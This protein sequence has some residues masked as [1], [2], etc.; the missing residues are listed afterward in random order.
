MSLEEAPPY[1]TDPEGELDRSWL[2][3]IVREAVDR[4]RD[5]L[6]AKGKST[7]F[8]VYE[9]YELNSQDSKPTY[10]EMAKRFGLKEGDV[11]NHLFA[12]R[13]AVRKEIRL[14]LTQTTLDRKG[15]EEEWDELFGS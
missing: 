4:V 1:A 8:L 15:F 5:R 2:A 13:G 14:I 9:E 10:A 3:Q 7:P 6:L 12:V 11:R